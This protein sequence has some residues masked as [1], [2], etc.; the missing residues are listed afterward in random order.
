MI[1]QQV[2]YACE[3]V[4]QGSASVGIST[5]DYVV[6]ASLRRAES[7]LASYT[8][9]ISKIDDH[10]G[11]AISGLI[12][13]GGTQIDFLRQECMEEKWRYES[14]MPIGRLVT[15]LSDK[16]QVYTQRNEKR[17]VGVGLLIAGYDYSGAHLFETSPSGNFYEYRAQ[18]I[19][20][21]AQAAKTY[22]E[23]NIDTFEVCVKP[24][25]LNRVSLV[26]SV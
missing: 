17:P 2:E 10:V 5:R 13:D 23:K 20:M 3:A 21:R 16:N 26:L 1:F 9:K 8:K 22:L 25:Y 6:L 19:G 24:R 11:A 7:N 4:K 12:P 14:P 18:A 15:A